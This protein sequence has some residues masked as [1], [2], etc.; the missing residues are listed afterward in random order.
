MHVYRHSYG[1]IDLYPT[2]NPGVSISELKYFILFICL[3]IYS[4]NVLTYVITTTCVYDSVYMYVGIFLPL[5]FLQATAE[6]FV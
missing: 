6:E 1:Y 4:L 2:K 3:I 5:V